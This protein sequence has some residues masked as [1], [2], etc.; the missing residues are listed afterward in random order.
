MGEGQSIKNIEE[1]ILL[2]KKA[3]QTLRKLKNGQILLD[4]WDSFLEN[5]QIIALIL[6]KKGLGEGL[7]KPPASSQQITTNYFANF[8]TL[9]EI[10]EARGKEAEFLTQ[11]IAAL[12]AGIQQYEKDLKELQRKGDYEE[13]F[14]KLK[15]IRQT[16]KENETDKI[17]AEL[18]CIIS[19]IE[20]IKDESP[21]FL[22]DIFLFL[23]NELDFFQRRYVKKKDRIDTDQTFKKIEQIQERYS[24]SDTSILYD[25]LSTSD[26]HKELDLLLDKLFLMEQRFKKK[27]GVSIAEAQITIF[28]FVTLPVTKR[29]AWIALIGFVIGSITVASILLPIFL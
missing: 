14:K 25:L 13:D 3:T 16:Y 20:K 12:K 24:T 1:K 8:L 10:F 6:K 7:Y 23:L 2:L 21:F 27:K 19:I 22:D 9:Y 29:E 4:D 11:C 26:I 5:T 18:N 15:Q 28:G 17:L